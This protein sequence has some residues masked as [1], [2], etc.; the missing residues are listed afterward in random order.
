M[1]YATR[2][3]NLKKAMCKKGP[4]YVR[5]VKKQQF[6]KYC[7]LMGESTILCNFD[8]DMGKHTDFSLICL[9]GAFTQYAVFKNII[10]LPDR[11]SNIVF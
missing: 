10:F 3:G 11:V 7:F 1:G 9:E 5:G 6:R 2:H 8:R 4:E